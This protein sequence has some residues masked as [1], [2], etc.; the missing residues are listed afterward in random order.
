MYFAHEKTQCKSF[1]SLLLYHE[2]LLKYTTF[3][4]RMSTGH[5]MRIDD[6]HS[7][8]RYFGSFVTSK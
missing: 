6:T 3:V 8:H 1:I 5:S 2:A 7:F 4:M